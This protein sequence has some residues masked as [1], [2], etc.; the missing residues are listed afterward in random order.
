[1]SI[2]IRDFYLHSRLEQSEYAWVSL[3]QIPPATQLKHNVQELAVNGKVLLEI[4]GG[5][6]GLPQAG[7]LAQESLVARL[8]E[9]LSISP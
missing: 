2:D 4:M 1:M 8:A 3:T 5:V 9:Q 7:R 6:Y